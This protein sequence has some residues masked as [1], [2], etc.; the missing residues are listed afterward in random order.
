[1]RT[2][3]H[4]KATRKGSND[5]WLTPLPL[6][7]ALGRFD[8]DPCGAPGHPTADEVWTPEEIGDGLSIPWHGRAW[9]NPPYG[10]VA[11]A[12]VRRLV[13]HGDGVALLFARTD[14]DLFHDWVFPH[15][16]AVMFLH[17]RVRFLTPEGAYADRTS[18]APSALIA[19]GEHN[20]AALASS[21]LDGVIVRTSH[22]KGTLCP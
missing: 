9:V 10:R 2:L 7:R 16:S 3:H 14:T 5:R 8:L 12:W 11:A 13:E 4:G 1:M 22:P 15:A 17:G 21:G 19:Y 20:A 18:G 6:I